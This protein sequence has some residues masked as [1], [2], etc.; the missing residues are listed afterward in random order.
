[1]KYLKLCILFF[2]AFSLMQCSEFRDDEITVIDTNTI[3]VE[4]NEDVTFFI[5]VVNEEGSV[6]QGAT[7]KNKFDFSG[8]S[9][10]SKGLV[11]MKRRVVPSGGVP[12]V[13]EAEGYM[14]M[15]K[16]LKAESNSYKTLTIEMYKFDTETIIE[17]GST[18]NI[19]QNGQ[20]T[21]PGTLLSPDNSSYTGPVRVMSHYYN[22]EDED[23]LFDAPG[24]MSATDENNRLYTLMSYGMY[25]I[26]LYDEAG[27]E[28]SIPDGQHATIQFPIPDNFDEIPDEIPLWSMNEETA[29]WEEEGVAMRNGDFFEAQ[30]SHFSWWNCDIPFNPTTVCMTLVDQLG[31][32]IPNYP[33]VISSPGQQFF[34][35]TASTDAAGNACVE[36]PIGEPIAI[37]LVLGEEL[38]AAV[39]LGTFEQAAELGNI[40]MDVAFYYVNGVAVDCNGSPLDGVAVQ[41]QINELVQFTYSDEQGLFKVLVMET[42]ELSLNL[43]DYYS[44]IQ[45]EEVSVQITEGQTSYNVGNITV[46][47]DLGTEQRVL[48]EGNIT[49]DVT[50]EAGKTYVL[51]ERVVVE[52]GVTLTIEPGVVVKGGLG[53]GPQASTLWIPQ[54]AKLMAEGTP[55]LPIVF[56]AIGDNITYDDIVAGNL[57]SPSLGPGVSG[58]WGG[59]VM[60]GYAPISTTDVYNM[61]SET[62]VVQGLGITDPYS[63]YGGNDPYDN[64]GV[65]RYVSIRFGG[66]NIGEGNEID[67]LLLG[68]VGSNTTIDHVEIVAGA[69]DG[70]SFY[71]GTVNVTNLVCWRNN[72]DAIDTDQAWSGTLDGF[73]VVVSGG[74]CLELDGPESEYTARHTIQNGTVVANANGIE[75]GG[76]LIDVDD[77][78][79]ADLKNIHFV[80]PILPGQTIT[81]DEALDVTFENVTFDV[82]DLQALMENGGAIPPGISS[83]GTPQVDVSIFQWTWAA[84]EGNL[85][86]L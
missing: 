72:D 79:P 25:N 64:S 74:S 10:N 22:P 78:T 71:G 13:V 15:V 30:V 43:Y 33:F 38:S 11:E 4:N 23:F 36:V 81:E 42:G 69:D 6:I 32:P 20:L 2:V 45:S 65:L 31:T 82:A 39:E 18:G 49:E 1:M 83:G 35:S 56:T 29:L 12:I 53:S 40:E 60:L 44:F 24:D 75:T 26:E 41:Y 9:T 55:D 21:L 50:W 17:T 57:E 28:L 7:I 27:N 37:S 59:V 84:E 73:V 34:Y 54:G 62:T 77:N 16:L 48:V 70:V 47:E 5:Q 52:P 68:G 46:C 14:K 3:W 76:S 66:Q 19:S 80:A 58:Q 67:G 8:Y 61:P 51:V 86:G 63:Y 85:D